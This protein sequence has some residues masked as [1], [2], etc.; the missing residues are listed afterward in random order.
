[1]NHQLHALKQECLNAEIESDFPEGLRLLEEFNR[2][3]IHDQTFLK[4]V[5]VLFIQH[6]LAPFIGRLEQMVK[7]GMHPESTWFVDIPYSSNDRVIK[8][9]KS[10]FTSQ[11]F[12]EEYKDP[13]KN[14]TTSQLERVKSTVREIIASNPKKVLVVDDGA[15]FIR[16]MHEIFISEAEIFYSLQNKVYIIEQTTRGHR[17]LKSKKYQTIIELLNTP[18]VSIARCKTKL[19]IESPFIGIACIL[20]RTVASIQS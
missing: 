7:N 20:K 18:I 4:D 19:D 16:A 8:K 14:Y 6:H 3:K 11:S 12:P 17:Y 5:S 2:I 13:L 9:I 10:D 1:M 15:Y